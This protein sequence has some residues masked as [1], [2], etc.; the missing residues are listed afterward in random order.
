MPLNSR[1]VKPRLEGAD[2]LQDSKEGRDGSVT[3]HQD[4]DVWTARLSPGEQASYRV[5][6]TRLVW[7]HMARG[8]ATLNGMPLKAGDGAAVSE[9]SRLEV[10]ALEDVE[11]LVF[12]LV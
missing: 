12:D 3:V 1:G 9:E 11:I 2:R 8:A 7:S 4:V 5:K 6:P 10:R